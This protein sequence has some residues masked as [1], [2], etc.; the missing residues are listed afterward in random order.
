MILEDRVALITGS[1]RGIGRAMARLFANEGARVFLTARSEADLIAASS[2][3]NVG[4]SG[5]DMAAFVTADLAYES[6]CAHVV[7][8]AH[9]KFG[10]IDILVNNAGHYGPV[11][12]VEEYPLADF[13]NV[14]AVHLRAAFLLSKL[15]LPEM[16]QR[17]SGVIL[18]ISSLSAKSAFGWGS[19][20]A[21][22]K[23]GMLGL[24]RVTAAEGA[25]RGVRVN[26]LCPGPVTETLMSKELGAT[27]AKK[28]GVSPEE[29]LAGFLNTILQG[30]GQT[31]D[32]IARAALFLC[33]DAASAITGQ[34]INVDGGA[35]FF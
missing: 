3:I 21:A 20:Y 1:G 26:A 16:Y 27:L 31:A 15:T 19:A 23:A 18:N 14:I 29:Q 33:S 5:A 30:R 12:P 4:S 24:T 10:R 22:A 25:R 17:G 34:A 28:L 35:A 8:A 6:D 32:E 13:D 11:V 7:T 2:E 9:N